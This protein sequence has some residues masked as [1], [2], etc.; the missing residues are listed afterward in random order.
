MDIALSISYNSETGETCALLLGCSELQTAFIS[1]QL[2]EL[3]VLTRHPLLPPTLITGYFRSMLN[4]YTEDL[5]ERLLDLEHESGVTGVLLYDQHGLIPAPQYHDYAQITTSLLGLIQLGLNWTNYVT[6][7]LLLI[8][9][10][11]ECRFH[12]NVTTTASRK[13]V[14]RSNGS[15]LD[16][17]L[18]FVSHKASIMQSRL[19]FII[20]R[21]Q[22]EMT[23]VNVLW[24]SV[25][26]MQAD[27]CL[28]IQFHSSARRKIKPESRRRLSRNLRGKQ[29]G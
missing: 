4:R 6:Q 2:K 16:E 11:Q 23:A 21:T 10:I 27:T 18:R 5:W 14:I 24:F 7:V 15:V 8:E 25:E 20:E 19:A 3:A 29:T 1:H 9:A 26:K 12:I 22:A 13:D 17:R 28:D